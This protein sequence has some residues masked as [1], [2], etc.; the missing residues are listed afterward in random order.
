M[1]KKFQGFALAELD[2]YE[3]L[4]VSQN[5]SQAD[6][7]KAYRKLALKYHPDKNPD[8]KAAEEKFKSINE[9][10]QV[11]GNEEQRARYDRYGK[12]GV[13]AN[14]GAGFDPFQDLGDIFGDFFGGRSSRSRRQAEDLD[15]GTN[16]HLEF[17]EAVFGVEKEIEFNYEQPC[18]KCNGTG[19]KDGA[20]KT[21]S[22]CRGHGEVQFSQGFLSV[23]QTCSAC[24]GSGQVIKDQCE[25]CKG[26]AKTLSQDKMNIKI[27]EGIDTGNRMRVANKGNVGKSGNRGDLYLIFEIKSD[28][29]FHRDGDDVYLEVPI[30]ITSCL[31]GSEINVP[32]LRG[33]KDINIRKNTRDKEQ[34]VLRDQG[35]KNVQNGRYGNLIL[36]IKIVYPD[37]LSKEQEQ[38]L[39]DLHQSFNLEHKEESGILYELKDRFKKWFD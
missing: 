16:V 30:F 36:V 22:Q 8:D 3:T 39:I 6:I 7:K 5:A 1:Q 24:G 34:I 35:I 17:L 19:S 25:Q 31:L 2:Y 28:K 18:H 11:L 4:E 27:P 32:T 13:G 38:L 23:R 12:A 15:I 21:C 29:H 33:S 26:K 37:K 14:A 20:T 9:A 10:Y